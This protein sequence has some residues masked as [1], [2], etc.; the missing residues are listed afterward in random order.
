MHAAPTSYWLETNNPSLQ[1]TQGG[2]VQFTERNR[3][4]RA[5]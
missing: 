2:S 3:S 5:P 4:V 1:Q